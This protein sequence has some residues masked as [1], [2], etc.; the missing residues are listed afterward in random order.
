MADQVVDHPHDG[1]VPGHIWTEEI[2]ALN[3]RFTIELAY[4]AS[5]QYDQFLYSDIGRILT[6][7]AWE[8]IPKFEDHQ[9]VPL[10]SAKVEELY[11][12]GTVFQRFKVRV[13]D[14]A[15]TSTDVNNV[16]IA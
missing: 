4:W 5:E 11:D 12:D 8:L 16:G 13:L 7:L 1:I 2:P 14:V 9:W 15:A 6:D 10:Y 3:L